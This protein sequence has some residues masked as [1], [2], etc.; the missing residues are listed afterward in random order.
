MCFKKELSNRHILDVFYYQDVLCDACRDKF[1]IKRKVVDLKTFKVESF[2][3]YNEAFKQA[4]LQYKECCDEA[5]APLF[6][7]PIY[8][9]LKLRYYGFTFVVIPSSKQAIE[10]RGFHHVAQMLEVAGFKTLSIFEKNEDL[11]QSSMPKNRRNEIEEHIVLKKNCEVPDKVLLVDDILTT[12]STM[13]IC[14]LLI[15][16]KAKTLKAV[17]FSYNSAWNNEKQGV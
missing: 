6:I 9:Y 15:K 17:T 3:V 5:L 14:H 16:N 12:G 8:W 7:Y 13:K 1:E 2:Y 4:I 10:K 11:K